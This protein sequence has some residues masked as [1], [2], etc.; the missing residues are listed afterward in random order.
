LLHIHSGRVQS[1][2]ADTIHAEFAARKPL[3]VVKATQAHTRWQVA[4]MVSFD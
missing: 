4:R 2:R 1:A 3:S